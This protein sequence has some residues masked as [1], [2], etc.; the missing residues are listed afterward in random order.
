MDKFCHL[1]IAQLLSHVSLTVN[2]FSLMISFDLYK[3]LD[4]LLLLDRQLTEALFKKV[5]IKEPHVW[6]EWSIHGFPWLTIGALASI[7]AYGRSWP[8]NIQHG[9]LLLNIGLVL[10]I[11]CVGILKFLV[12]RERPYKGYRQTF[13]HKIDIYSFPSGHTSRATMLI[14]LAKFFTIINWRAF[15]LLPVLV[16]T[17]RIVLGRHYVTDVMAG[18]L[19]GYLESLLVQQIPESF[20]NWFRNVVR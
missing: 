7:F 10:D 1:K 17:S 14:G 16:G 20:N 8:D 13:E 9:F 18:M 15:Y 11:C 2:D 6:I 12:L 5:T 19:L 3:E 4:R